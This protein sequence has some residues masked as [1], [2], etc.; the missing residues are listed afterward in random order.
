M[1]LS[2]MGSI[3]QLGGGDLPARDVLV[4]LMMKEIEEGR[5]PVVTTFASIFLKL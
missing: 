2:I 5:G 3:E 4:K 1:I